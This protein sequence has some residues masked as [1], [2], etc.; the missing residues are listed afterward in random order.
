VREAANGRGVY[1]CVTREPS[2][3]VARDRNETKEHRN[4]IGRRRRLGKISAQTNPWKLTRPIAP[5]P[6]QIEDL[7]GSRPSRL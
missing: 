4:A 2:V 6:S 3:E 1:V 5:K 7:V